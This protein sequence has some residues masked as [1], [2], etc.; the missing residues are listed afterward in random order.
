MTVSNLTADEALLMEDRS[1]RMSNLYTVINEH[2]KKVRFVPNWAQE[3]LF[4]TLGHKN[5]DL[6]VRQIGITT[7]YCMLWLDVALFSANT[8]IGIVAHTKGDVSIIMRQ[9]IRYAWDHLPDEIKACN[10]LVIDNAEELVFAN[11][12]SIRAGVTFR[13]GTI[14]ILHITEFGHICHHF[15]ARAQEVL[16][17]SMQA[18]H[19]DGIIVIESTAKGR[20]GHFFNM[21]IEAQK[22]GT[23]WCFRFL[24]WYKEPEYRKEVAVLPPEPGALAQK[25]TAVVAFIE[26]KNE[27]EYLDKLE[28]DLAITLDIPQ[29][30]WW[31]DKRRFLGDDVYSEF[32]STPEEAFKVSTDGAYYGALM[33]QA[34][35]SGR[36]TSIPVDPSILV[37]TWWDLGISDSMAIWFVQI[38][39]WEIRLVDY[40]EN[41]GEGLPF[42][43]AH[44]QK[45]AVTHNI[46][47][48]K[49]VA[50]HDIKVREIGSGKSRLDTAMGL[51]IKFDAAP[52]LSVVDGIERVRATIPRCY[53][54]EVRCARGI[55][56]LEH[57]RK[58][59]NPNLEVYKSQPLH[60]W[61]SHGADAFRTGVMA[62]D[63]GITGVVTSRKHARPIIAKRWR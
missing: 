14:Q 31:C 60:N 24:P 37:D 5:I 29:R 57:Y 2:G 13:S 52:M 45:W 11:G 25:T 18:V 58:E 30:H 34:S 20:G 3:E 15:P 47:Y 26:Q 59:W 61:A 53:F 33:L 22:P 28:K 43:A 42:Y 44:L 32:P 7:G 49:H 38:H 16:T 1:W 51:G 63:A 35:Q 54:D 40:Y 8:A 17:G 46:L 12:S 23:D 27:T 39:G 62:A 41:T 50:P 9:K 10:P 4:N 55:E 56:C 48:G 36:V 19:G 6:K 21:C